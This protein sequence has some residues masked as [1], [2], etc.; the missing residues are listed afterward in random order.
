[1]LH[2]ATHTTVGPGLITL[3]RVQP[4]RCDNLATHII[5]DIPWC[6]FVYIDHVLKKS[7]FSLLALTSKSQCSGF[8]SFMASNIVRQSS[9]TVSSLWGLLSSSCT[10]PMMPEMSMMQHVCRSKL[11]SDEH[12]I[13]LLSSQTVENLLVDPFLQS[14]LGSRQLQTVCVFSP[15]THQVSLTF[16]TVFLRVVMIQQ[17]TSATVSPAAS[18]ST[19]NSTFLHSCLPRTQRRD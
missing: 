5:G 8:Q 2:L 14:L 12:T 17:L 9:I 15:C 19:M 13:H 11:Q 10:V 18:A 4:F 6:L 1:M 7:M 16:I 3:V